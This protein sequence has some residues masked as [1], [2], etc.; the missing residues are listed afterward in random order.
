MFKN[1]L[2]I[3][4][5]ITC[6]VLGTVPLAI[7]APSSPV[8]ISTL[9]V[10]TPGQKQNQEYVQI[11]NAGTTAVNLKGWKIKDQGNIH[12]YTF[13]S[14]SLK[15]KSTV[16]L[17]SGKGT[18]SASTLYWQ[19]DIF[20]WNNHDPARHENGDTAYLYNAQGQLISTKKG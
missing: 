5:S 17:R 9:Y 13:P 11:K 16:T 2:L 7:C 12:T 20:I 14:Y 8:S 18:N 10:G 1:R 19:K 4:V 15:A 3:I 6:L